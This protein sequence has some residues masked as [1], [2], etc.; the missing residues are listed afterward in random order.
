MR[1]FLGLMSNGVPIFEL[2][3]PGGA[4]LGPHLRCGDQFQTTPLQ[5]RT[6][7]RSR[8]LPFSTPLFRQVDMCRS[9][10]PDCN[11]TGAVAPRREPHIGRSTDVAVRP[12]IRSGLLVA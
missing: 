5:A 10:T 8:R 4:L 6:V 9:P 11:G 3:A 1:R 2:E 7:R 12:E